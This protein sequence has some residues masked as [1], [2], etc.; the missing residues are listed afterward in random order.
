MSPFALGWLGLTCSFLAYTAVVVPAVISFHWLDDDCVFPPTLVFD[1]LL[2]SFFILDILYNFCVG[3]VFQ[4]Q[5][6][7]DWKWVAMHY[8]KSSF[9]FDL[10]TSIPGIRPTHADKMTS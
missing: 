5:Y 8:L 7:D 10:C 1:C 6:R 2:D 9:L 3:V 4:G